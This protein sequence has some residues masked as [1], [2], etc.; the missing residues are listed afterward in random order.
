[1]KAVAMRFRKAASWAL[2]LC[3]LAGCSGLPG[4]S[5]KPD[6]SSFDVMDLQIRIGRLAVMADQAQDAVSVLGSESSLTASTDLADEDAA[7]FFEQLHYVLFRYNSVHVEACAAGWLEDQECDGSYSPRWLKRS[8]RDTPTLKE[9]DKWAEDL[10]ERVVGLRSVVC[11][12]AAERTG[13]EYFCT[14]E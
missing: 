7:D 4:E 5:S 3:L 9:L 11:A 8:K 13:N 12:P 10:Q 1:M 14:V 2:G 6:D